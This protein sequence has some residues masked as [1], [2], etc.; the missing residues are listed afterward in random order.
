MRWHYRLG[1]LP[2]SRLKQ[3]AI[4]GKIPKKLAKVAPPKCAG[5]LFGTMTKRPWRSKETKASHEVFVTTK[6]GE[7][8]VIIQMTSTK[9]GFYAQ[10]KGKLTKKRYRCAIIFVDHFSRL[11]Y[12]HPQVDDLSIKII[13]AKRAFKSFTAEHGIRILHYHWDNGR[14]ADNA[15]KQVCHDARQQLTFCG[16]SAHFQNGIAE[17]SIRDLFESTR[18]QLLH[19]RTRWPAAVHFGP[20]HCAMPGSSTIAFRCW[21][22]AHQGSS[23]SAQF[24]LVLT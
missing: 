10:L 9:P 8:V 2:F 6:P 22:T 24:M 12:M 21:R 14:F 3:L 4:N 20:T 23:I 13:A 7:C 17:G 19:A 16:V 11:R 1:H 15:F 18:K 5:C